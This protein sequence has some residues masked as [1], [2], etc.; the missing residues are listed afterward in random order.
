MTLS[1]ADPACA[2]ASAA[3]VDF[4]PASEAPAIATMPPAVEPQPPSTRRP[5]DQGPPQFDPDQ[6]RRFLEAIHVPGSCFEIRILSGK[7]ARGGWIERN[8]EY[9]TT[10]AGWYDDLDSAVADLGRLRGVSAYVTPNP[11]KADLLGISRNKITKVRT[12]TADD[13]IQAA[14]FLFIDID[15]E[16]RA[17]ISATNA[18]RAKAIEAR[19]RLLMDHPEIA[20]AAIYG[21]SGNG[22]WVLAR[23]KPIA[24][25]EEARR[26]AASALAYLGSRYSGNGA[27]VDATTRNPARVCACPGTLKA[28]GSHLPDRPWRLATLD[29]PDGRELVPLDLA[30]WVADHPAPDKTPVDQAGPIAIPGKPSASGGTDPITRARTYLSKMAPAISGQGGHNQTFDMACVLVKGFGLTIDQ[31]RPIALE[32]NTQCVPPW[33]PWEIEHKLSQADSKPDDKPRG[34]LLAGRPMPG[35]PAPSPGS[36]P[37]GGLPGDDGEPD[38]AAGQEANPHRLARLVLDQFSHPDRHKLIYW[39][40]ECQA[41]NGRHY[42]PMPDAE[43]RPII[44]RVIRLEF[45]RLHGLAMER[46]EAL[47]AASD[48]APPPKMPRLRDVTGSLTRDVLAAIQELAHER[49]EDTP[50]QPA[51]LGGDHVWDAM[52]VLP[53]ANSLVHLASYA[54]GLPCTLPPT[55]RFFSPFAVTYD[56]DPDAPRP[57]AWSAFVESLWPDDQE[58]VECL[59]EWLGYLLTA[60]TSMQKILMIIGPRRSGKGTIAR[61]LRE[62]VGEPNIAAPTLTSLAGPF[63]S[64]QLI[65][66]SVA[67]CTESRLS[68]RVDSQAIVER[69]L[70]ISGE[71]PQ[72]IDRK[73]QA[74]WNGTLRTRFVLTG[75]SVPKLGDYSS[76]LPSRVILLKLTN[77]FLGKEDRELER[78]LRAELPSIL[79]WALDGWIRL[80]DRG[81]FIQ[82]KSGAAA[83]E[84]LEA[85]SN[86]IGL[87]VSEACELDPDAY[88]IKEQLFGAWLRWCESSGRKD[89]GNLQDFSSKLYSAF[90]EITDQRPRLEGRR[91]RVFSGVR[92]AEGPDIPF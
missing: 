53:A 61:T 34:Y 79:L 9:D 17:G 70:S 52:G 47:L 73:H 2:A 20:E 29:S 90:P 76:A 41:W 11:V 59:Q 62:L 92:L 57:R 37:S 35:E 10:L 44:V 13:D 82:P 68:G 28:K 36:R 4:P 60:D 8:A 5:C 26:L 12:A 65:G 40:G 83:L 78:K 74:P 86:P 21:T 89:A 67:V 7:F 49:I 16:R 48:D 42:A 15:S 71:D 50:A 81:R 22:A 31:A 54:R 69:L 25:I 43:L 33:E 51:W 3:P 39:Q 14:R 27:T 38:D 18:E 72:T 6:A 80:M 88:A 84:E 75:N 85:T 32:W 91:I 64:Q 24:D 77:S 87:F 46:Y 45:E 23:I 19:D 55:P 1:Y 63:G 30:A 56:F 58:A 66:K